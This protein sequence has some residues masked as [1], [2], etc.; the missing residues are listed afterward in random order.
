MDLGK[1]W[2]AFFGERSFTRNANLCY[3][4]VGELLPFWKGGEGADDH[5]TPS[6]NHI[7]IYG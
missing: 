5:R 3:N 4:G 2:E 1:L 7:Y 6:V